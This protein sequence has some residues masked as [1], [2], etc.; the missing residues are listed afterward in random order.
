MNERRKGWFKI[1]G[2]QHGDR[3][4]QEQ[5][6]G[7]GAIDFAGKTV[8]D[9]G[10]AEGL[11][12]YY[13]LSQGAAAAHGVEIVPGRIDEARRQ[14]ERWG[15]R[16]QFWH[17]DL[18]NFGA[19]AHQFRQHYDVVLMLAILHK[20]R[21]PFGLLYAMHELTPEWCVVRLPK[22][23]DGLIIDDR[24]KRVPYDVPNWFDRNG[25]DLE[26]V[27][28]GHLDEWTGYFRQRP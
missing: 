5:L 9:L 11:I 13:A 26:Q 24:S 14:C 4:L 23:C 20:L 10:C 16:A 18:V 17:M 25:Y 8:L 22:D 1:A 2:V 27:Q 3:T 21:L 7:L 28:R 6:R 19:N 15:D 12:A